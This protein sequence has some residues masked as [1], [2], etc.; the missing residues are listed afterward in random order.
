ML[1]AVLSPLLRRASSPDRVVLTCTRGD[2]GGAQW[3][4]RL[5]V[6]AFADRHNM[7]YVPSNFDRVVPH[8]TEEIRKL[9]SALFVGE[10]TQTELPNK[11]LKADS[12]FL[13]TKAVLASLLRGGPVLIDVG[14]MHAYTDLHPESILETIRIHKIRYNNPA[15]IEL[16]QINQ[17]VIAMHVRRGLSWEESFT[18]NRLTSD[19]QVLSRL[20]YVAR[21]TEIKLG[22][23]F[24]AVPNVDL[25]SKL[26]LGYEYDYNSD[27]FMVIHQLINA[28]VTMLAKSCMSYIAGVFS[29]G[30]VFYDPFF[31]PPLPGWKVLGPSAGR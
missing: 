31:H 12:L 9:W 13:F 11:R 27:E 24:S 22:T 17:P 7:S 20:G 26:P 10:F 14:H 3:H 19:E 29:K 25:S 5:T 4:G 30:E 28:N 18:P 1:W 2:G 21:L 16:Q 6:M 15:E 8:N 23:V